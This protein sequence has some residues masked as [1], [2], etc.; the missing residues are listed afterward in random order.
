MKIG[1]LG[2]FYNCEDLL[3]EVLKPWIARK[4]EHG[5]VVISAV[6]AQFNEYAELGLPNADEKTIRLLRS[7]RTDIDYLYVSDTPKSEQEIRTIGLTKLLESGIDYVWLLD[8]DEL[9]TRADIENILAYVEKTPFDYYHIHLHNFIFD[10][11]EWRDD[12]FPPRIF[13][14]DRHGGIKSFTWDNELVYKDGTHANSVVPGIVPKSLAYVTHHTWRRRDAAQKIAYHKKHFGYTMYTLTESGDLMPD[15]SYFALHRIPMPVI[16]TDGSIARTVRPVL[17]V[18]FRSHSSGNFRE[19]ITRVTDTLGGKPELTIR[20]LRSIIRALLVLERVNDYDIRLTV[21]DDHS[22]ELTVSRMATELS[23]CPFE[24]SLIM[25]PEP[26]NIAS[27]TYTLTYAKATRNDFIHFAED[28]YLYEPSSFVE[29]L[30]S[31][32]LFTR[33]VG[34][35]N[36]ALFPVDQ[37]DYYLPDMIVPTRVVIGTGRHWRVSYTTPCTFFVPRALFDAHFDLFMK[38][39]ANDMREDDSINVVWQKHAILFSP[40]PTLAYHVHGPEQMPAFSNWKR[41][42]NELEP[43]LIV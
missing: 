12:F 17:D 4:R 38:N 40:L 35:G 33:N 23:A 34:H 16:E 19:S 21:L 30:K 9:Y 20:S 1:V 39:P 43:A 37:T 10:T 28:D 7:Y 24:T 18:V 15:P 14:T 41:L 6:H 13:R 27:M 31:H 22:D 5:D 3:P 25:L 8:G 36:I 29:M 26:G 32:E 11:K 42:W 2:C